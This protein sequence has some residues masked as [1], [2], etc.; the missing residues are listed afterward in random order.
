[1]NS[2]AIAN[3]TSDTKGGCR[4]NILSNKCDKN[5]L[6]WLR[7]GP[8][9]YWERMALISVIILVFVIQVAV[10]VV[11]KRQQEIQ[12]QKLIIH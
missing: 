6:I 8:P 10:M 4:N 9:V 7:S 12:V 2:L 1:M 3:L 5:Y 11:L